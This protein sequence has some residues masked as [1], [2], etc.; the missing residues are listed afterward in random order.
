MEVRSTTDA[1]IVQNTSDVSGVDVLRHATL[2][3]KDKLST[4][5]LSML[6]VAKRQGYTLKMDNK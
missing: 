3:Q 1:C 6:S 4:N 5:T 2:N